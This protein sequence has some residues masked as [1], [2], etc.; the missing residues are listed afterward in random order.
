LSLP[1][2]PDRRAT[3]DS[4]YWWDPHYNL[5]NAELASLPVWAFPREIEHRPASGRPC[6]PARGLSPY[7][8][9]ALDGAAR[10][11]IAAANGEQEETLNAEAFAIGTLAGAGAVPPDF[12]RRVLIW[13]AR[14]IPSHDPH[15]PWL[16]HDL[17]AKVE[18]AFSAGMRRPRAQR[19]MAEPPV[20]NSDPVL[21]EEAKRL[22]RMPGR[23]GR[24]FQL[25]RFAE[26]RLDPTRN[27]LV[28]G[29]IPRE[30]IVVVWGPPKCGKSFLV[31][32]L[33]VHVA[34]GL[35]YRGRRV[36]QGSVVY[37][38]CEGERGFRARV[39]AFRQAHKGDA[40]IDPPFYLLTT[41]LDLAGDVDELIQEIAAQIG[42]ADTCAAIVVDT[43]NRSLNG[44]ESSDEDMGAYIRAADQLR[45][46][47]R[48]AVII[49]HHCGVEKGRPRGHTSLA[50]AADAQ[51]AVM[52]DGAGGE[53]VATV[54]WMKDDAGGEKIASRLEVVEIGFDEDGEP[55]TSCVVVP[56]DPAKA[57]GTSRGPGPSARQRRA[58][59]LLE[60]EIKLHGQD[61]EPGNHVP[62][63]TRAVSRD[64]W[65][66]ACYRG[67][68]VASNKTDAKRQAFNRAVEDLIAKSSSRPGMIRIGPLAWKIHQVA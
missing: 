64:I 42:D 39:E 41:R 16:A 23:P 61:M 49:I 25:V 45:E 33:T 27:C 32:D 68:G 13:A 65:R 58:L 4:G 54:E 36:V 60:A 47:F 21:S 38:A 56:A 26:I 43:L 15:R 66:E 1:S 20:Y 9:A 17:D 35:V 50:G 3:P 10:R 18:R 55:I 52:R 12:A 5:D 59:E 28:Q 34:L 24:S 14:Q 11:I 40:P 31:F 63:F 46:R 30:G 53:I 29:F 8:E 19:P 6:K 62:P 2:H 44:S 37:I 67:L 48:C 57:S 7:A 22:R 51:I